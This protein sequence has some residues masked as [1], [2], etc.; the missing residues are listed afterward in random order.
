M[1]TRAYARECVKIARSVDPKN[2]MRRRRDISFR[3]LSFSFFLFI[4]FFL[5]YS[6]GKPHS[7]EQQ[8]P[9][10]KSYFFLYEDILRGAQKHLPTL[11]NPFRVIPD[12]ARVNGITRPFKGRKSNYR[13]RSLMTKFQTELEMDEG[14]VLREDVDC[15][16]EY[17]KK[18]CQK[19]INKTKEKKIKTAARSARKNQEN[20]TSEDENKE[21]TKNKKKK[22]KRKKKTGKQDGKD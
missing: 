15:R 21:K 18:E 12:S 14:T 9:T 19:R 4:S 17:R 20:A 22:N 16:R 6:S 10:G 13:P 3:S 5:S 2:L 11:G 8:K 7:E 1:R